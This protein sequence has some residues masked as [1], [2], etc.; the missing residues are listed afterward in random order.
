MSTYI[1]DTSVVVQWF[2]QK[3][4]LHPKQARKIFDDLE[5]GR[6]NIL[7][8]TILLVELINVLLISKK[9]P[10]EEVL[11]AIRRMNDMHL[12]ITDLNLPTLE[13]TALLMKQYNLTSYDSYFLALAKTE[14]C[15]LISDDQKA[16]GQ[17]KDGSVLM[18]KN[19]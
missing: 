4:E 15:R 19:Y 13:Y 6:I 17:I 12:T 8:P 14:R 16:H 2:Q 11:L 5:A 1:L 18:L 7:I 10:L 3:N 9:T